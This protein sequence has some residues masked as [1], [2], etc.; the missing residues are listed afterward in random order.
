MIRRFLLLFLS[1]FAFSAFSDQASDV[2]SIKSGVWEAVSDLD[3]IVGQNNDAALRDT[4]MYQH[5]D[6]VLGY[7]DHPIAPTFYE[8]SMW[9]RNFLAGAVDYYSQTA[10]PQFRFLSGSVGR[11]NPPN[12]VSQQSLTYF[13]NFTLGQNIDYRPGASARNDW[14]NLFTT[15]SVFRTVTGDTSVEQIGYSA[16]NIWLAEALR[17]QI[18]YL[19]LLT[20]TN[21]WNAITNESPVDVV[22][23]SQSE[24]SDLVERETGAFSNNL[25]E[26]D[27]QFSI[28]NV[29]NDRL[30][31]EEREAHNTYDN[32]DGLSDLNIGTDQG[33]VSFSPVIRLANN[34]QVAKI[35]RAAGITSKG[36]LAIEWTP[37]HNPS[38][39]EAYEALHTTMGTVWAWIRN[40]AILAVGIYWWRRC[41]DFVFQ[42]GMRNRA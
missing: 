4:T 20:E 10:Y 37:S 42:V 35:E 8:Q 16:F 27:A 32:D 7:G 25:A 17:R 33:E 12:G 21:S 19:D 11:L 18:R 26:I 5:L 24:Q 40:L 22:L 23:A 30:V 34:S 9:L 15:N 41:R 38:V 39:G 1:A 6:S 28:T 2:A 13:L 36:A 14:D 3:S 31:A 29:A